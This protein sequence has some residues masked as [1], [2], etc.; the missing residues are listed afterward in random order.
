VSS[1]GDTLLDEVVHAWTCDRKADGDSSAD[2]CVPR[3]SLTE[4]T[5]VSQAGRS[6]A[7][8]SVRLVVDCVAEETL[9]RFTNDAPN[10]VEVAVELDGEQVDARVV[11][12]WA[13]LDW[14][15]EGVAEHHL[16]AR[17]VDQPD[18]VLDSRTDCRVERDRTLAM[19]SGMII[20]L[21]SVVTAAVAGID[22]WIRV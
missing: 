6:C 14:T 12:A 8:L 17:V 4:W 15:V 16:V 21:L 13:T 22:P 10:A 2:P 18:V 19:L 11:E 7:G 20:G 1:L 5:E 9:L 3:S